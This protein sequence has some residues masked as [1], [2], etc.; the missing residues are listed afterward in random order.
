MWPA[1]LGLTLCVRGLCLWRS[2][3]WSVKKEKVYFRSPILERPSIGEYWSIFGVPV[4]PENVIFTFCRTCWC[5]SEA[6]NTG[7]QKWSSIVQYS[8][9]SIWDLKYTFSVKEKKKVR[10]LWQRLMSSFLFKVAILPNSHGVLMICCIKH[11]ISNNGPCFT[12]PFTQKK[13]PWWRH[14]DG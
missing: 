7:T 1:A 6:Y 5:Y 12:F 3:P 13:K 4:L 10:R 14:H 2:L 11:S 8:F 9:T